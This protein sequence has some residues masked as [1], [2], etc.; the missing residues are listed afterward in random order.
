MGTG[1]I[2]RGSG[3]WA[4]LRSFVVRVDGKLELPRLGSQAGAWEPAENRKDVAN[5]YS[6]LLF[7]DVLILVKKKSD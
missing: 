3:F 2:G 6:E 1:R 4:W 5:G 7:Y